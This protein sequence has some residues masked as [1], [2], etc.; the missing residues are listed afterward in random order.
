MLKDAKGKWVETLEIEEALWNR[1]TVEALIKAITLADS[2]ERLLQNKGDAAICA[3]LYMYAVEEYGKFLLLKQYGPSSGKVK[4]KYKDEFRSHREKFGIAVEHLPRECITLRKGPF[5]PKI[6]APKVFDT[7]DTITD[8]ETRQAVFYS[9]F[10]ES[11]DAIKYIPLVDPKCL[12]KALSRFTALALETL[13]TSAK[14]K[15]Q[16]A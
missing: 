4:V 3:G 7:D 8:C 12:E 1:I 11:G 9:D 10:S 15:E 2:A 14:H 16:K 13:N 5:D 6:F